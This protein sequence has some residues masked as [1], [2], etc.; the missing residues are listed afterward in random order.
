MSLCDF[1]ENIHKTAG[2]VNTKLILHK[3]QTLL[4]LSVY[5]EEDLLAD[6]IIY[7]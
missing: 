6:N 7:Q 4:T 3:M 5:L 1:K 2:S